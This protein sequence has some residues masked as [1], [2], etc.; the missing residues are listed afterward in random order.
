MSV[1]ERGNVAVVTGAASGIGRA[2]A[3][4]FAGRGMKLCLFD[5]EAKALAELAASLPGQVRAIVGDVSVHEDVER[6]RDAAYDAFGAVHVLMNNAAVGRGSKS[7]GTLAR[8]QAILDINLW[9]VIHGVDAFAPRMLAQGAPAA[10]VNTGS[11]QGITN[12]PGDPAYAVAKAGVRTLTEQ[13]AHTLRNEPGG[14]VS[15]HLLV[16]GWTFTAMTAGDDTEKPAGAWTPEQVVERM[17]GAVEAGEFYVYCPDNVVS[18]PLDA[19]RL[20]WSV[21]DIIDKRP[22]LSRWHPD[23]KDKFDAYVAERLR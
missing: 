6:L 1:F 14:Q 20:Q 12:P 3:Q 5:R 8:W 10:I 7:W 17:I 4:I 19:L 9:G 16:P 22:A 2:A 11:K 23:W 21:G 15:A 18:E 13:L